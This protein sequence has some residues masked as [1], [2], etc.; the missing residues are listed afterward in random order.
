MPVSSVIRPW[1]SPPVRLSVS[2]EMTAP[3]SRLAQASST[4]GRAQTR[5][6]IVRTSAV[7]T[8]IGVLSVS[9]WSLARIR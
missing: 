1:V 9:L 8:A 6:T 2:A 4:S 5:S 3:R 7:P